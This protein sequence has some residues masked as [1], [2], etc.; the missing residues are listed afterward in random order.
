TRLTTV[1]TIGRVAIGSRGA[2][3]ASG[4]RGVGGHEAERSGKA[5]VRPRRDPVELERGGAPAA[6]DRGAPSAERNGERDA[7]LGLAARRRAATDRWVE[8][9]EERQFP[10]VG[11][12]RHGGSNLPAAEPKA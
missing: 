5:G 10:P 11:R 12:R 9:S 3:G 1:S 2:P 6:G 8:L 4:V 7:A